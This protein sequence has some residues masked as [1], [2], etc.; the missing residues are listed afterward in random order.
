MHAVTVAV[1]APVWNWR[2]RL[3]CRKVTTEC[4]RRR[5]LVPTSLSV[6]HL[7]DLT[8]ETS[9]STLS[10][11]GLLIRR[12]IILPCFEAGMIRFSH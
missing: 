3:V 10:E 7:M 1:L 5:Y 11:G 4:I 12:H 8:A 9:S 2:R 6:K